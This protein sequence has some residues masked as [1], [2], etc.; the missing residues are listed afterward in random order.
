MRTL[1]EIIFLLPPELKD[2]VRA[3]AEF[4]LKTKVQ[5]KQKYLRLS[6]KGTLRDLRDQYASV[7][8]QHKV[9][10]WWDEDVPH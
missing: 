2:E 1:E 6:W 9:M 8:L 5:P 10:E 3:F 7:E 4:L